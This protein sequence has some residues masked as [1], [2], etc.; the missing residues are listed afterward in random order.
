MDRSRQTGGGAAV[1]AG[2]GA[3]APER[4][5]TNH[6]LARLVD[7]SDEWIRSRTGIRERRIA[8]PEESTAHMGA[9]AARRALAAAGVAP[10]AV[11]L[12]LV[13]TITPDMLFPASA[14]LVQAELG[15]VQS[16]CLDL[17]A[18][19]SGFVYG[20]EVGAQ[21]IRGGA[22]R[23]VLVIGAE[24]LSSIIDWTDRNTCV[25]FG[26]GAG[27]ALLAVA[28]SPRRRGVI[29]S[30]LGADGRLAHILHQP[31]GGARCP[32][33]E[34][35]VR[36]RLHFLRMAGKEVYRQAVTAMQRAAE[37]VLERAGLTARD[38]KLVI[39]HQANLRIIDA[40]GERL[41]LRPDQL[42]I[43]LERYGNTSAASVILALDEAV[44]AGQ[45]RRGDLFMLV[46][47]G[48]GLTWGASII[49]Y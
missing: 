34:E 2:T 43:N 40:L 33:S 41:R 45:L 4:V 21:F 3:Y 42:F 46:A 11:D 17:E 48:A 39:P 12:I 22:C 19:C 10:A 9:Q 44:R 5:L 1:I 6:E 49:E 35:S 7:T 28:D 26:D 25:L 23:H 16:A 27:A 14:C 47:F 31:G 37:Q 24:K 20:V 13:A 38:L 15:A 18:A 36:Q 29:A 32:A 30:T 8:G